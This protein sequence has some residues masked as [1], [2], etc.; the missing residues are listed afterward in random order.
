MSAEHINDDM[1]EVARLGIDAESFLASSLGK[2]LMAQSEA[3][4]R[5]LIEELIGADPSDVAA[6][7]AIRMRIHAC[8]MATQ[9]L[10]NIVQ[11]GRQA[12]QAIRDVEQ[13]D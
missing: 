2:T 1:L 7:T 11:A 4:E 9:R 3:E 10:L 6:N 5:H 13:A 8:R 12:E